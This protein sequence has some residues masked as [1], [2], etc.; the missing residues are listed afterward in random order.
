ML[1]HNKKRLQTGEKRIIKI[2]EKAKALREST[3][4][5]T[6]VSN[7]YTC[8]HQKGHKFSSYV[9]QISRLIEQ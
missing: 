8:N 3:L 7:G 6:H 9:T 4:A 1:K 5:I 2:N